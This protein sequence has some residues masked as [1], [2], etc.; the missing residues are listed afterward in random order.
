MTDVNV[1][2]RKVDIENFTGRIQIL[3]MRDSA[4]RNRSGVL[5]IPPGK[6]DGVP[7][8]HFEACQFRC[9]TN[10]DG[11]EIDKSKTPHE[12]VASLLAMGSNGGI[13]VRGM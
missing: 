3:M 2:D 13:V 7:Y 1:S 6:L 5:H 10:R 8:D 4:K 11:V 12:V 9:K